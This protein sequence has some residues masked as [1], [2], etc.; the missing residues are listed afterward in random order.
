[1]NHNKLRSTNQIL[2]VLTVVFFGPSCEDDQQPPN[3]IETELPAKEGTFNIGEATL[4]ET[5]LLEVNDFSGSAR[6]GRKRII[7]NI[8]AQCLTE[9][10]TSISVETFPVIHQHIK[11]YFPEILEKLTITKNSFSGAEFID[12]VIPER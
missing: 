2:L 1:M 9:D 12:Y 3:L 4:T 7:V 6:L 5:Q 11:D 10:R 8:V